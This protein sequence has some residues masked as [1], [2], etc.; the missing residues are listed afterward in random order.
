[1]MLARMDEYTIGIP[2][3]RP[4]PV[5]TTGVRGRLDLVEHSVDQQVPAEPLRSMTAQH[6]ELVYRLVVA[7]DIENY[8]RLDTLDQALAQTR[9]SE[10]LALAA[11]RTGLDR[12]QWYR[13]LR[14]DGELAVLPA[15]TDAAWVVAEFT[16]QLSEALSEHIRTNPDEPAVRLRVAMHHGTLA[17]GH[18]GLAGNA[19]VV[20]CRLLDSKTVRKALAEETASPLVLVISERL[21]E[22]VVASRFHGLLPTR[23]RPTRVSVKGVAYPGFLCVGTPRA[24]E[25]AL[26][27]SGVGTG[28]VHKIREAG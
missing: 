11:H 14:G 19:P 16:E 6:G 1:M 12:D 13:Q 22:D 25:R 24:V 23:F 18:F 15:D 10:I 20:T 21:Y 26:E 28:T 3:T 4:V 2:R 27:T 5:P 7:V 9:L 17:A 8:S